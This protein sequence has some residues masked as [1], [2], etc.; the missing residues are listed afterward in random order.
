V[1]NSDA[2]AL[3]NTNANSNVFLLNCTRV[4]F[5]YFCLGEPLPAQSDGRC[6]IGDRRGRKCVSAHPPAVHERILPLLYVDHVEH[7]GEAYARSKYPRTPLA[8]LSQDNAD[9]WTH[10]VYNVLA[11]PEMP[12]WTAPVK[13]LNVTRPSSLGPRQEQ[14]GIYVGDVS[15]PVA[16]AHVCLSKD[17]E[18]YEVA[19]RMRR[20]P[21]PAHDCGVG[22]Q[23][24]HRCD[25]AQPR[26][27]RSE[28]P[29]FG[30]RPR[31][32]SRSTA[33]RSTTTPSAGTWATRMV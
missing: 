23:R 4:A 11:D 26:P 2:D 6:G 28:Y 7:I 31:R 14:V 21:E 25:R 29:G 9:L 3:T 24:A 13:P 12:V 8:Q 10:Y 15:G 33:T 18:D 5:T 20:Q 30:P 27:L 16:N 32:T 1:V 22:R 17:A 19:S